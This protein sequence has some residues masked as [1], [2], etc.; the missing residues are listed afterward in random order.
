MSTIILLLDPTYT[1]QFEIRIFGAIGPQSAKDAARLLV[2]AQTVIVIISGSSFVVMVARGRWH[3]FS[4][5]WI[6][7]IVNC[8]EVLEQLHRRRRRL[9]VV[10]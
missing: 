7:S 9:R 8:L 4:S 5:E 2:V 1:W 3:A 10:R 6:I